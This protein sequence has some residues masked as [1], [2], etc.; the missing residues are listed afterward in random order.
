M[1]LGSLSQHSSILW[2]LVALDR[3]IFATRR[4][5]YLQ[6]ASSKVLLSFTS[7]LNN[8]V[9]W[10]RFLVSREANKIDSEI[11]RD[12]KQDQK[13]SVYT[14]T[15]VE[16][17]TMRDGHLTDE[18]KSSATGA[19][20]GECGAVPNKKTSWELLP[21]RLKDKC[22]LFGDSSLYIHRRVHIPTPIFAI[23]PCFAPDTRS[24]AR[25]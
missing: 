12:H 23:A 20:A 6:L 17:M 11:G 24:R 14:H 22:D 4:H 1:L 18:N 13:K 16:M 15:R 21:P 9:E 19:A 2:I 7:S 5:R 3:Y 8:A 10:Y 25:S